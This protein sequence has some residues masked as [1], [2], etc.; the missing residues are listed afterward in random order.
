MSLPA[1]IDIALRRLNMALDQM[2]AAMHRRGQVEAAR[3][4]LEDE[5]A[6]L[7]DDRSRLAIELDGALAHGKTLSQANQEVARRLARA[8][9]A[10]RIVLGE[11][12]TIS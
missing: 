12:D 9:S 7:Q 10:I 6:L 1:D 4:N 11:A 3:G 2:E 5:L 8:S